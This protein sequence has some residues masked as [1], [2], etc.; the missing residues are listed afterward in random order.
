LKRR[1]SK[2]PGV[3]N[4]G[5]PVVGWAPAPVQPADA[6]RRGPGS[7]GDTRLMEG[8]RRLGAGQRRGETFTLR[9][10]ATACGCDKEYIKYIE[11]IA[12]RKLQ[13]ILRQHPDLAGVNFQE[14]SYKMFNSAISRPSTG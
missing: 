12:K 9:R 3:D 11:R 7:P 10:I 4:W 1:E 13:A 5:F 14:A 2:I 8:L 6:P